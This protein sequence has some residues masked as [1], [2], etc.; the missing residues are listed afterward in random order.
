[1][2]TR[3]IEDISAPELLTVLRTVEAQAKGVT[4]SGL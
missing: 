3:P 4:P 2:G 1:M